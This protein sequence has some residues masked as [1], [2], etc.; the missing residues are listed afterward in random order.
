VCALAVILAQAGT[1]APLKWAPTAQVGQMGL[2]LSS[3]SSLSCRTFVVD[4]IVITPILAVTP[5][6]NDSV[7]GALKF[8]CGAQKI[9]LD[10]RILLPWYSVLIW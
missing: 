1:F 2:L 4:L 10:H 6:I 3:S 8:M 7:S 5:V 9:S